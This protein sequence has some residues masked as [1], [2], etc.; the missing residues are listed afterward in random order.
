MLLSS[1]TPLAATAQREPLRGNNGKPGKQRVAATVQRELSSE[2]TANRAN[3]GR[4][5]RCKGSSPPS[6]RQT[7]RTTGTIVCSRRRWKKISTDG[8]NQ[9]HINFS[10]HRR[11]KKI[12]TDGANQ[13]HINFSPRRRWKKISTDGV[14]QLHI[15]FSGGDIWACSQRYHF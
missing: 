6:K 15:N 13:L 11:W 14:N 8:A 9:L 10:P 5:R 4:H 1:G 3:N 2:Q 7:E 12:S